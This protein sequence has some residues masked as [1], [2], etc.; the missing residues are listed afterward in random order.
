[1]NAMSVEITYFVHGTTTDNEQHRATGWLPGELSETGREQARHLGEQVAATQFDVVLCSDLDRAIESA[2]LG[3]G[4]KYEIRQDERLRECNYG[5]WNGA[6]ASLF[7][8]RMGDFVESPFPDGE[9]Y[10]D[11]EKRLRSF[12]NFLR[13]NY[14]GKH[15]A[16]VAHQ[17]PQLALDVILGGK[18]WQQAIDEDWRKTKAWQPGWHYT[19]PDL[20]QRIA[21]KAVIV[22]EGGILVL[23]PSEKDANR[24]WHFPGGIRD[25]SNESLEETVI[26]ETREETGIDLTGVPNKLIH[27]GEW[28]A[29]DQG[30]EVKILGLFFRFDLASRPD[31]H[32]SDEHSGEGWLTPETRAD[33]STNPEVDEVVSKIYRPEDSQAR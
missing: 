23:K 16:I 14:N 31:I 19:V 1:M 28:R 32:K 30:E 7:K 27:Y 10:R 24:N 22:A 17:G 8:D 26:R 12:T 29:V 25:D 18:T 6:S 13:D 2:A 20:V 33:F 4:D 5:E 3:F 11:V 9:S 15:V 21:A